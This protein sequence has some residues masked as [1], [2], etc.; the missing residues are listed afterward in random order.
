MGVEASGGL[1]AHREIC[2]SEARGLPGGSTLKSLLLLLLREKAVRL[3]MSETAPA[4]EQLDSLERSLMPD[5]EHSSTSSLD[6]SM[7]V[8]NKHSAPS[9]SRGSSAQ[10]SDRSS[11]PPD[12][13]PD[14]TAGVC[15]GRG[16][17][18][19]LSCSI[20]VQDVSLFGTNRTS[21]WSHTI[22]KHTEVGMPARCSV[23]ACQRRGDSV[24][25]IRA[26]CM[27]CIGCSRVGQA[28]HRRENVVEVRVF[29]LEGESN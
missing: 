26:V 19:G 5:W 4:E 10:D 12:H 23:R 7:L 18:M 20:T 28:S 3:E 13:S 15:S 22:T 9:L 16:G 24:H 6:M 8:P 11:S 1:F 21:T 14:S 29:R 25:A 17:D 27:S 2:T